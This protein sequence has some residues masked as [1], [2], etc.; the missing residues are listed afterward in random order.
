M[1]INSTCCYVPCRG[2]SEWKEAPHIVGRRH[3][4]LCALVAEL[5]EGPVCHEHTIMR[6]LVRSDGPCRMLATRT[7]AL[8]DSR[9]WIEIV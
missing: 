2:E 9:L 3:G 1:L 6:L 5:S 8:G 7:A 4:W